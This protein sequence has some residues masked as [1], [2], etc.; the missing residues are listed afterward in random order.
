MRLRLGPLRENKDAA[1]AALCHE[2]CGTPCECLH[3]CQRR[4]IEPP[5][6]DAS[7]QQHQRHGQHHRRL[8]VV[9]RASVRTTDVLREQQM[10]S[11]L[12]LRIYIMRFVA[13]FSLN[14]KLA[15]STSVCAVRRVCL[16]YVSLLRGNCRSLADS[17]AQNSS[18]NQ[19]SSAKSWFVL[20]SRFLC[21]GL[22][23]AAHTTVAETKAEGTYA[24]A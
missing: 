3:Y 21:F 2:R 20:R 17:P 4:A 15:V 13:V 8:S 1:I 11:T 24:R 6:E 14:G 19:N 22:P 23:L 16:I 9:S 10:R 5:R 12:S 18:A 7:K